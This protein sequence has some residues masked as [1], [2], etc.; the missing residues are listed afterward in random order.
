MML[1]VLLLPSKSIVMMQQYY[2]TKHYST[3]GVEFPIWA[4]KKIPAGPTVIWYYGKAH[5]MEATSC[6]PWFFLS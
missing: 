5:T 6:E 3:K 2:L 1:Q 4:Q